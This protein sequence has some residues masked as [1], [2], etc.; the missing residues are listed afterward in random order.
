MPIF[1]GSKTNPCKTLSAYATYSDEQLIAL[2]NEDDAGAFEQLYIRHWQHLYNSAYKRL[3][4]HESCQDIV[5]ELF[6]DLWLRRSQLNI[7]N[8]PGYLHTAVRFQ[9]LK[10]IKKDKKTSQFIDL[11]RLMQQS[12]L[13][14]D[15][16]VREKEL[17]QLIE[18]F[19]RTLP[20]A[21]REI[22]KMHFL[23]AVSSP[24]IAEILHISPKTVRNQVATAMHAMRVRLANFLGSFFF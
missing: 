2:L 13:S 8:V 17:H 3:P 11:W 19:L 12:T 10:S 6:A 15:A 24:E 9:I 20:D 21:R 14:A 23:E 4:D 7:D 16:I 18:A 1:D 5:Q 22:F